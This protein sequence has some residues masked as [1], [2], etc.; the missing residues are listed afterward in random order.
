LE[1]IET[2]FP[3]HQIIPSIICVPKYDTD[4]NVAAAMS[5]RGLVNNC[6]DAMS[7]VNIDTDNFRNKNTALDGKTAANISNANQVACWPCASLGDLIVGMSTHC[8][9][10]MAET[11][12]SRNFLPYAS[13]SC[14]IQSTVCVCGT[15]RRFASR[16]PRPIS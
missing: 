13:P 6:F 12:I 1:V 15:G 9:V 16:N 2:V 14:W 10:T 8:A 4:H 5:A 11:D 3:E 7:T